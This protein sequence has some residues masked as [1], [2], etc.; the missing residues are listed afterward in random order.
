MS[1]QVKTAKLKPYRNKPF[2]LEMAVRKFRIDRDRG[3]KEHV[4]PERKLVELENYRNYSDLTVYLD[5]DIS[6][7]NLKDIVPENERNDLPLSLI[8]VS[9]C[10]RTSQREALF[11]KDIEDLDPDD[12]IKIELERHK[13]RGKSEIKPYI[14]RNEEREGVDNFANL[15][16]SKVASGRSWELRF[17]TFDRVGSSGLEVE[18]NDFSD[19]ELEMPVTEDMLYHL[20]MKNE[21]NPVLHLNSSSNEVKRVMESEGT[22]GPDARMRDVFFNSIIS[23]VYMELLTH[24]VE[25]IDAE[26][27][28]FAHD[29]QKAMVVNLLDDILYEEDNIDQEAMIERV[30]EIRESEQGSQKILS[31]VQRAI[32]KRDKPLQD[33]EKLC[34]E[35][36]H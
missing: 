2:A 25:S 15:K 13:Y 20:N 18:W 21:V 4:F 11:K 1:G 7:E 14:V 19:P 6:R 17:D 33:M 36:R 34:K 24:A 10:T 29:W 32:H 16:S 26:D 3:D 30:V 27:F 28:E 8:I 31:R 22:R 5:F 9:R 12:E 23:P 35:A